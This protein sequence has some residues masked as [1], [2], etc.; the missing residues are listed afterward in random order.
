MN[1]DDW[2]DP[3]KCAHY[4]KSKILAEKALWELYNK[5]DLTKQHTDIVSVLPSLVLG[6]GLAVHGNSSEGLIA[7]ILRGNFPGYPTPPVNYTL[8]DVRDAA[9]GHIKAMWSPLARRQRIA[10]AAHNVNLDDI[11]HILKEKFP[12]AEVHD[13]ELTVDQIKASGNPVA[14]RNLMLA[15]KKFRVDNSKSVKA[16]EL[17][18]IPFENTIIDMANQLIKLG[19]VKL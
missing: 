15:G 11:F 1:E 14:Q 9:A 3:T 13:Q 8:V 18:Y 16:L 12:A 2:A 4:P 6:P 17:Q 7:E 10:L 5:Q 19:V